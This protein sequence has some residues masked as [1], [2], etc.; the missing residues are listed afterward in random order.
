MESAYE[1]ALQK[2]KE[3]RLNL[4]INLRG[5]AEHIRN[6]ISKSKKTARNSPIVKY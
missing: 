1:K 6:L 4:R 3:E 2:K 5:G